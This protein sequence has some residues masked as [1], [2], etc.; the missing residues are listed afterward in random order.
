AL[1]A[2][3]IRRWVALDQDPM[4]V[5]TVARDVAGTSVQAVNGSVKSLRGGRHALGMFDFVY[6]AGLYDYLPDAV[7]VKLTR[8]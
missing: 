2:G 4:S 6:A 5:G 1:G 3:E 7:A 8:K